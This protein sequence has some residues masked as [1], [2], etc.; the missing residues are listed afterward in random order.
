MN[1]IIRVSNL[2]KRFKERIAVNNISF[3]VEKG[4]VFGFLG[5]NGA[6]KSTT[7]KML[8]GLLLPSEGDILV[9]GINPT[10]NEKQL[11]RKIG[12]VPEQISLY[13]DMSVENNLKFFSKL[14]RVGT[15]RV[16]E[17]IKE[18]ELV[19]HSKMPIKKLSKGYKQRVLIARALLHDPELIFMDE[20]TSG[21][22][23]NIAV[24]IREMIRR[25]KQAGKTIFLTTHYMNEAEELCDDIAI[26]DKGRIMVHEDINSLKADNCSQKLIVKTKESEKEFN[27][28]QLAEIA[29]LPLDTIVSIH[30]K[31]ITLEKVFLDVTKG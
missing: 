5:T 20:P 19:S 13:E 24:E 11:A 31:E 14:Y 4:S 28:T 22:D 17:V 1:E 16:Q 7:I 29:Q 18:L 9:C 8:T 27:I 10:V 15:M 12:V 23:P 30:S 25:L 2:T 26:I 3:S 6:G 21:L